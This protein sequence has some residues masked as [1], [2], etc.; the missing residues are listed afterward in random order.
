MFHLDLSVYE[1]RQKDIF[2]E[3]FV[4]AIPHDLL[5]LLNSSC[6]M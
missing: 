4:L 5:S 2:S 1:V 3:D 6:W